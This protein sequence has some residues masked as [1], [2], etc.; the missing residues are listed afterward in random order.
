MDKKIYDKN[1]EWIDLKF[2]DLIGNFHH[3]TLPFK[4]LEDIRKNGVGFDS[5]SCAGF[6][7]VEGGD[8]LLFPDENTAF[9]DPFFPEPTL[10]FFCY[11]KEADTK[12]DYLR[13]PRGIALKAQ[14]YM[15]KE[16][17]ADEILFGPEFEFY[18][19][20][21]VIV[22]NTKNV[23]EY[24]IESYE[25]RLGFDGSFVN[26][27]GEFI[28]EKSGY[29]AIPPK[30][31]FTRIR[32]EISKTI[33]DYGIDLIYHHH[34]VGLAQNEIEIKRYGILKSGDNIQI[35][36][37]FIKN[38]CYQ[39]ELSATFMPKP[40]FGMPGNGMHFH[41]HLFKNGKNLF[42]GN[43]YGGL[44]KIGEYYVGGLLKHGK[45]LLAFTNPSTN[46]YK[47]L[48]KGF[49]AP[50]K[51]FYSLANRSAAIR[52]PK[53]ATSE[54]EKRIE[55]R[56]PDATSNPYLATTAMLMAGLDGI[57]KK[58]SLKEN[59][60]GPFEGDLE[61]MD[62]NIVEKIDSCPTNLLG[63]L[64]ELKKDYDY[65]LEGDVFN[66]DLIKGYIDYKEKEA[67][68][69]EKRPHPYEFELYF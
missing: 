57:K 47:R 61:K 56:P 54:N 51:L 37:Y 52:I 16:G 6:K 55:F 28:G 44:S 10:S 12:G 32:G 11:I 59:N 4:N 65:L 40:L 17:I 3:I 19:F 69:I 35:I 5:S 46:S 62:K 7:G 41:Q 24:K 58:I 68:D 31:K 26:D 67:L 25:G 27:T 13:D 18:I 33:M 48:V 30:D 45:S 60:F 23:S 50:I 22:N 49:E 43:G 21:R 1:Y 8:M 29:H 38:I 36:K 42:F 66:K 34:E 14:N 64:E 9:Q 20:D 39:N 2:T 53:Y 15:K 63:A